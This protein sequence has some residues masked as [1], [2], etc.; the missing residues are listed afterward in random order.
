MCNALREHWHAHWLLRLREDRHLVGLAEQ[1]QVL[2][3]ATWRVV[4]DVASGRLERAS[5][6][7]GTKL[8]RVRR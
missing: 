1:V 3:V 7:C 6:D 8:G 2:R 5:I 4:K